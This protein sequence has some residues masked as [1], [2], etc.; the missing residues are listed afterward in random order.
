MPMYNTSQT[1]PE[2]DHRKAC[3]LCGKLCD[4]RVRCQ[5]DETGKWHLVCPGKC[6]N[7]VSGG[8]IDGDKAEGHEYYRYGGMWKNKHEAVSAK[9]PRKKSKESRVDEAEAVE[10]SE[11]EAG[12]G[13]HSEWSG[14]GVKYTRNGEVMFEEE[15]WICRKSHVSE[16]GKSPKEMKNLWKEAVAWKEED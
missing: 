16:E 5:I 6:W 11:A 4:V 1:R 7:E 3:T 8:G 12:R 13:G 15:L 14:N 2:N 10:G 9:K